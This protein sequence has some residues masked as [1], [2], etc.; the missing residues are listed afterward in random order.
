MDKEQFKEKIIPLQSSMQLLAERMLGS[1]ADSEDVVQEVFYTLWKRHEELD[2]IVQLQS[3]CMQMIRMRCIDKLRQQRRTEAHISR[4]ESLSDDEVIHEIDETAERS[5]L[6]HRLLDTLPVQQR[7]LI[8][9]K[10]FEDRSVKEMQQELNMS[11]SNL[12]TTLSRTLQK[13]R[14]MIG[15][16]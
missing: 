16:L 1:V 6:L 14:G 10:Y 8:E 5:A 4:L 2:H 13:L 15:S 11:D 7:R 12:Y 3:Y 9:M